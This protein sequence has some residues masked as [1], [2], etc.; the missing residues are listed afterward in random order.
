MNGGYMSHSTQV[1][2]T[3]ANTG[4]G[5]AIAEE[6]APHGYELILTSPPGDARL[7]DV[8]SRLQ[9]RHGVDP[10]QLYFDLSDPRQCAEMFTRNAE[11]FSQIDILVNNAGVGMGLSSLVTADPGLWSKM[12]D[13]N[14]NGI[15]QMCRAI[16]PGM[17]RRNHGHIVLLGSITGR[18][19]VAKEGAYAA[20]KSAVYAL[21]EA[22]RM[23]LQGTKVRVT[24]VEPGLTRTH[25]PSA[26]VGMTPL[27]PIDVARVVRWSVERPARI[28]IQEIVMSAND[29]YGYNLVDRKKTDA[30]KT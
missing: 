27:D 5:Q 11:R 8:C 17:V 22:M 1:L 20:T 9:K 13:I 23:D 19:P 4:I 28:N 30:T 3:G 7:K 24:L 10:A 29:Q 14:I 6:L 16:V 12:V 21:S 26:Y 18:Y 15:L 2:I 25:E